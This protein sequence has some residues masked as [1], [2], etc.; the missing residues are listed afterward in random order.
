MYIRKEHA[1]FLV[2]RKL[3]HALLM[4]KTRYSVP[5][6][7]SGLVPL[8]LRPLNT[9]NALWC[10]KANQGLKKEASVQIFATAPCS[11][12]TAQ[13][14]SGPHALELPLRLKYHPGCPLHGSTQVLNGISPSLSRSL[15]PSHF[16]SPLSDIHGI[17]STIVA[18]PSATISTAAQFSAA[19]SKT[20]Q[21]WKF[22]GCDN[23][24]CLR[25]SSQLK[26]LTMLKVH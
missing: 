10:H 18:T 1:R 7:L 11:P 23:A 3:P 4:P 26:F 17:T 14:S 12:T 8:Q 21:T 13:P 19:S 6:H 5:S 15:R 22:A 25:K 24:I 2:P 20:E 9:R 16:V